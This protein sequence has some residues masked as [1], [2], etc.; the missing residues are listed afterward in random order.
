MVTPKTK[1]TS[2][3]F[4]DKKKF[5]QV[6]YMFY[7]QLARFTFFT[8]NLYFTPNNYKWQL[9]ES[10]NQSSHTKTQPIPTTNISQD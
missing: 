5:T 10:T 9:V 3:N 4:L 2:F 8:H 1:L 7:F 6:S